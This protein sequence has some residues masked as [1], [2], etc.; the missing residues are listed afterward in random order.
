MPGMQVQM[1][2]ILAAENGTIIG[3]S[4]GSLP[5]IPICN[6]KFIQPDRILQDSKQETDRQGMG[7]HLHV[8]RHFRYPRGISRIILNKLLSDDTHV[9]EGTPS[10]IHSGEMSNLR[11]L[12]NS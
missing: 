4:N 3:S 8:Y 7:S 12:P 1:E 9:Y 2:N 10:R 11:Q 5:G 6:N